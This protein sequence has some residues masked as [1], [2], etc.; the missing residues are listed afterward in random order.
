VSVEAI[1]FSA[2]L[3]VQ[4]G[5]F[6]VCHWVLLAWPTF[7]VRGGCDLQLTGCLRVVWAWDSWINADD[8]STS[9]GLNPIRE[10]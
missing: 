5:L 8:S 9:I 3:W 4:L 6:M 10:Y 2:I 7:K 1:P